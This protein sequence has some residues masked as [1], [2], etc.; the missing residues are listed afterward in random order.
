[1]VNHKAAGF[2]LEKGFVRQRKEFDT[3]SGGQMENEALRRCYQPWPQE[4]NWKT[5]SYETKSKLYM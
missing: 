3:L 2:R 1:M 5:S 4:L